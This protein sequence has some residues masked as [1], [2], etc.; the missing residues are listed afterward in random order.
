VTSVYISAGIDDLRPEHKT[1]LEI[2]SD[3]SPRSSFR[4]E[5]VLPADHRREVATW[6]D[7]AVKINYAVGDFNK[8]RREDF[9]VLLSRELKPTSLSP[10]TADNEHNP[11]FPLILVVFNGDR[12]GYKPVFQRQLAG[13][14][15]AFIRF[16]KVLSYGVFKTDART[17]SRWCR[18]AR[19]ILSSISADN[20]GKHMTSGVKKPYE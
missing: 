7:G 5:N 14:P 17:R 20:T 15:A 19:N 18:M 12:Q 1:A 10:T 2:S 11:N 9:A 4:S 3:A 16:D 6:F 8:D 13:L